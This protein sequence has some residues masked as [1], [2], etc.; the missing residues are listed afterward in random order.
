M[1]S[2]NRLL[3]ENMAA[4]ADDPIIDWDDD[5]EGGG[6]G[7]GGSVCLTNPISANQAV[8]V[9]THGYIPPCK[10]QERSSAPAK[11]QYDCPW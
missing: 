8:G 7:G 3:M 4:L 6:G 9:C 10:L 5:G 2:P 11:P 1:F